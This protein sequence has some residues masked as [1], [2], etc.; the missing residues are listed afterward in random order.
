M[1]ELDFY[2][3]LPALKLPVVQIFQ[4]GY[5]TEVPPGWHIIISDVKNSTLAVNAGRH[6]D[7]NLVAAGSLIAAL[8]VAKKHNVEVPFFFGGDGGTV[9]VPGE[10][11]YEVLT[12][13]FAHNKNAI[14][15]FGLELHIGSMPVQQVIQSGHSIR[16]AKLE[17]DSVYSKA[18]TI[19]DGLRFA[20]QII[21]QDLAE[22]PSSDEGELNLTGL[23]CRWNKVKPPADEAENVC[24]LIEAVDV[25]NH[26]SVYAAT[27]KKIEE[28]Y[29]D[30]QMRS[31]L[32]IEKLRPLLTFQKLKKEMLAKFGR[33]RIGYF[34]NLFMRNFL[35]KC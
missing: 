3:D 28:V 20:E 5:F 31:P 14:R 13:L 15:N 12:G 1:N 16:I 17:I 6:N 22:R 32:S 8:N 10:L 33:W 4:Y 29:G 34:L 21:K 2:R 19:G 26:L 27:F 11:L 9:L 30:V 35:G 23:E 24:Y 18:I 7:V 25:N